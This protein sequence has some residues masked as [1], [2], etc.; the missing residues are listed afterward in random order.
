MSLAR[1]L[2]IVDVQNDFCPGGA[3]AVKEGD[4]VVPTLNRYIEIF[5]EN[6][7]PIIASR[8]WHPARTRH[9]KDFGGV[10]PVH[11]VQ[12][13]SGAAFHPAL[14]L[15][16][17][18]SV[19]SKGMDPSQDSYSAF[20]AID[21]HGRGLKEILKDLGVKELWIGGLATDYCVKASVLDAL[22]DFD[23]KL[24]T[25]AIKGVELQP[26]DSRKAVEEMVAKGAEIM[27]LEKIPKTKKQ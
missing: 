24:L 1:A 12:N 17:D 7:K 26:G 5:A 20:Q 19:V 14:R 10:W 8:D 9:F 13:T 3:L 11:C 21:A 22:K 15:P 23:V 16:P 4:Q 18:A 6:K 2:L 27:S 25:D